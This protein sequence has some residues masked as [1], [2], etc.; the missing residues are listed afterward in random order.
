MVDSNHSTGVP[1]P[2]TFGQLILFTALVVKA[3]EF[4]AI[5]SGRHATPASAGFMGQFA[6]ASGNF[7][8][9]QLSEGSISETGDSIENQSV[10]LGMRIER[11]VAVTGAS[12]KTD[13]L[14]L[15]YRTD[16]G[17]YTLTRPADPTT[18]VGF[19]LQWYTGTTADVWLWGAE[20]QALKQLLGGD[21]RIVNL[22]TYDWANIVDGDAATITGLPRGTIKSIFATF[23]IATTGAAGTLDV[24]L[25]IDAVNVTGGVIVIPTGT[26]QG[27][28]I[29][30]TA[31]TALNEL[32]SEG[33]L[34]VEIANAGGT[35][36][37][38]QFTLFAVMEGALD[39]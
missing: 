17:A 35:R 3:Q 38:G 26:A 22:G 33:T 20:G 27:A 28:A 5:R 8:A 23:G 13:V 16:A 37:T 15:I 21:R 4:V 7:P 31:I 36:T 29:A 19:I 9:G 10:T 11:G 6:N 32:G 1:Y 34:Q 14:K 25:E 30:G 2:E 39:L 12:A 24:N 18:S